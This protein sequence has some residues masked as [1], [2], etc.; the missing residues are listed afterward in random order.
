MVQGEDLDAERRQFLQA[1]AALLRGE[2]DRFQALAQDIK[3]YPLYPYLRYEDLRRRFE[4]VSPR[5]IQ[6]FLGAYPDT[7]PAEKLRTAWLH[8]LARAGDWPT[9][10]AHYAPQK[11]TVL[12]CHQLTARIRLN[13]LEWVPQE[14]K[15]LWLVGK[16][17]PK[18]C[19]IPFEHLSRSDLMTPELIWERIRLTM[20]E[21][22]LSLAKYLSKRLDPKDQNWVSL[23]IEVHR[24]TAQA[25]GS[26]ALKS[27]EPIAREVLAHGIMRLAKKD[28]AKA[29]AFWSETKPRHAFSESAIGEVERALA[30]AAASQ[31]HPLAPAWLDAVPL[32]AVDAEV[33]QARLRTAIAASDWQSLKRWTEQAAAPDMNALGWRYWRARAL[34]ETGDGKAAPEIYRSLAQETDYYGFLAADRL[35][36]PY[37]MRLDPARFPP[38]KEAAVLSQPGLVR[39]RELYLAGLRPEAR[40]EWMR[41]VETLEQSQLPVVAAIAH[42]W[43]WHDRAILTLGKARALSDLEMRFPMPHLSLVQRYAQERGLEP[44]ILYGF[45]RAESAFWED[46]RSPAGA[47]GLMQLMPATGRETARR[48][49][50]GLSS[51]LELLDPDKNVRL[52]SAYL[53]DMLRRFDGHVAMAAAAYNAGP[54]RAEAWRPPRECQPADR[55]VELIP[56]T[57]T[58]RYVQN[59]LFYTG[60]YEWRLGRQVQPLTTRLAAIAPKAA[61]AGESRWSC[62]STPSIRSQA[63]NQG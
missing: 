50:V 59:I 20:G 45:I 51:T 10:L 3:S 22:S 53:K 55:W 11:T 24:E 8:Q 63:S 6:E 36:L 1:R 57:E 54:G 29:Y 46:A 2:Q 61:G 26:P 47:L 14:T 27:D 62:L 60:I 52:G 32:E 9:F 31:K 56:F 25:L 21:G 37:S 40:G 38:G 15:A 41:L 58:R 44:A 4:R 48:F 30:L 49:G 18:E 23:W 42:R 16:D 33:Q 7:P 5:E 34:E 13:R 28:A 43:G 19:E 17:Q 12:R 35:S 39:A